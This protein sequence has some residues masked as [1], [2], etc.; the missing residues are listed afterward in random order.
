ML[1]CLS[2]LV[3]LI[4]K[5]HRPQHLPLF[6]FKKLSYLIITL[7]TFDQFVLVASQKF[8]SQLPLVP[9]VLYVLYT[10]PTITAIIITTISNNI[11]ISDI[12]QSEIPHLFPAAS[13]TSAA[14]INQNADTII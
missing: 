2:G 13:N 11:L 12:N 8:S 5:L 1:F 3:V 10:G 14:P 9:F 6:L 7:K 4:L